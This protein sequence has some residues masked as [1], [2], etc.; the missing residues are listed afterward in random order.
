MKLS[1]S[2]PAT[3]CQQLLDNEASSAYSRGERLQ[4]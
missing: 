4:K 3:G 2:F 1:I